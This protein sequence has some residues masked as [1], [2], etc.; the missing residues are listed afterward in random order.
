[1]TNE[2]RPFK[3]GV[4]YHCT[5]TPS[6]AFDQQGLPKRGFISTTVSKDDQRKSPFAVAGGSLDLITVRHPAA[7]VTYKLIK[8]CHVDD[9]ECFM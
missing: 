1:M 3:R 8:R 9:V 7:E 2:F 5:T 4:H 6:I